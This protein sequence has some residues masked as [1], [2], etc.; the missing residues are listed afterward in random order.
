M[1][2][3]QIQS[4][5]AVVMPTFALNF[6]NKPRTSRF[7]FAGACLVLA[8]AGTPAFAETAQTAQTAQAA[9]NAQGARVEATLEQLLTAVDQSHLPGLAEAYR[10]AAEDH[11]AVSEVPMSLTV[12]GTKFKRALVSY[13]LQY[14]SVWVRLSQRYWDSRLVREFQHARAEIVRVAGAPSE[15]EVKSDA[16]VGTPGAEVHGTATK[17]VWHNVGPNKKTIEL[18]LTDFG[19]TVPGYLWLNVEL[20]PPLRTAQ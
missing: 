9:D 7:V 4:L 13:H 18:S 3:I 11:K 19:Q 8:L 6:M 15:P 10:T 20:T 17:L 2:A 14:G 1:W 12:G 5:H 16:P